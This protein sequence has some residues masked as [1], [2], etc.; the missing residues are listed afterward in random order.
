MKMEE[1]PAREPPPSAV[2]VADQASPPPDDEGPPCRVDP[3]QQPTA[4]GPVV[5]P[6]VLVNYKQPVYPPVAR[7]LGREATVELTVM[8]DDSGRVTEVRR[9]GRPRG[10]G[11]D[12]AARRAAYRATFQPGTANSRPVPMATNLS[13]RFALGDGGLPARPG[14]AGS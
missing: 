13:V 12:Q 14:P 9:V 6:P 7:R 4:A 1:R 8:V 3:G 11:F 10:L 5:T 2:E